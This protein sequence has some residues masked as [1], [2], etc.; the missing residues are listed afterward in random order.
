MENRY[1]FSEDNRESLPDVMDRS[2]SE[3]QLKEIYRDIIDET[4]YHDFQEW[5]SDMLKSGL[6]LCK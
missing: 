4:E 6:I 5:F 3:N 2:F 1:Y